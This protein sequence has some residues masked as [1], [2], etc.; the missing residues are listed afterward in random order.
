V[1]IEKGVAWGT[2][3]ATP[4]DCVVAKDEAAAAL[5]VQQGAKH[6]WLESGDIL[7][8]LG[9]SA[10][11]GALHV[12]EPCRLL[13]CDVL[14]VQLD[15]AAPVLALSSVVVGSWSNPQMWVTTGGFLGAL[16]VA[17][18][19]HVNDGVVD[20]LEFTGNIPLRQWLLMRRRMRLG[21]H[22]PHP[23]LTMHR[24]ADVRWPSKHQGA[25]KRT[26]RLDGKARGR[27]AQVSIEVRP[28]AFWL[29]VPMEDI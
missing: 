17:P 1:T 27:A 16:N 3:G 11:T 6:V 10:A 29:C 15:D 7:R 20:A 12:G 22:L 23:R 2:V 8:A 28:D 9:L 24:A 14:M 18:R 19:A 26:I 13:P 25:K 4:L 21:D 5:A